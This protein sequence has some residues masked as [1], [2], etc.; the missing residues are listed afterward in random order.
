MIKVDKGHVILAGTPKELLGDLY[1]VIDGLHEGLSKEIGE[2][3]SKD[4]LKVVFKDALKGNVSKE[5]NVDITSNDDTEEIKD[6]L[7][8]MFK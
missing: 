5:T 1:C 7:E 4:L 3:D 6:I 2:K 8:R